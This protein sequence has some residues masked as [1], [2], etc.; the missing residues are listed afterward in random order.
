MEAYRHPA[1]ELRHL[2]AGVFIYAMAVPLV[3]LDICTEIYHR[4]TFPLYGIPYVKR[5]AYIK[6]DREKLSYLTPAQKFNC[7]FCSYANGLMRYASAI[8]A[9]T[10]E[11]WCGIQHK[12]TP[13]FI[14]PT[15]Q[16]NFLPYGDKK[17]LK[18]FIAKK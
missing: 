3:F 17:A 14:Q 13:G 2:L 5:S 16:K 4:V 7:K 12:K 9:C 1:R 18:D 11:Y 10:E 8:G 6:Y 15:Y